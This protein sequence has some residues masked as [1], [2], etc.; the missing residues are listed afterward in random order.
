MITVTIY[1]CGVTET[2]DACWDFDGGP[3]LTDNIGT[4][5]PMPGGH[6]GDGGWQLTLPACHREDDA[7]P[8]IWT[9]ARDGKPGK[10]RHFIADHI[11]DRL[12][13]FP[14]PVPANV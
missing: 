10:G 5:V 6:E 2:G 1:P 14:L 12:L 8:C 7:G 4:E 11:G 9:G 3:V 13:I